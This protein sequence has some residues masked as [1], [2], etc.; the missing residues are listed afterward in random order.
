MIHKSPSPIS[1]QMRVT[2]ELPACVWA[3]RVFLAG[4]FNDW[5]EGSIPFQQDRNG[6]WRA[7]MDL[8]MGQRFQFRYLVDGSWRT[9]NHADSLVENI[10]RTTNSVVETTFGFQVGPDEDKP[11]MVFDQYR[12]AVAEA[13]HRQLPPNQQEN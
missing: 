10:Y 7:T 13:F 6:V 12:E 5:D 9:D 11:S 1:G 4:D 2:F 3:D 8:P